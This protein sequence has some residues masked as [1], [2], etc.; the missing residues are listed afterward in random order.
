MIFYGIHN[1]EIMFKNNLCFCCRLE[2]V[3]EC[4]K[5]KRVSRLKSLL[6][7]AGMLDQVANSSCSI[8]VRLAKYLIAKQRVVRGLES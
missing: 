4:K 1:Y 8:A 2:L 5:G 6:Q 3:L 7:D